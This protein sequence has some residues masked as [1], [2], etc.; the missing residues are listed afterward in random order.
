MGAGCATQQAYVPSQATS[1]TWCA[2]REVKADDELQASVVV[3]GET[4]CPDAARNVF[5][6]MLRKADQS[7]MQERVRIVAEV[8]VNALH[9]GDIE[10]ARLAF[11]DALGVMGGTISNPEMLQR[12]MSLSGAEQEKIFKGEPHER[13]LCYLYRG[14]LYMAAGEFDNARAC[15]KSAE[16]EDVRTTGNQ[17]TPGY[18]LSARYFKSVSHQM[19]HTE[20]ETPYSS[21][22]PEGLGTGSWHDGD[23]TIVIIATGYAPRKVV[24][25]SKGTYGLSYVPVRSEV[26]SVRMRPANP[27]PAVLVST[28]TLS[29]PGLG[30]ISLENPSEDVFVQAI[31]RGRRDMDKVLEAK[32]GQADT[33]MGVAGVSEVVGVTAAQF[34]VYGLP[35]TLLSALISTSAKNQA[36]KAEALADLRQITSLPGAL[37]MASLRSSQS[38]VTLEVVKNN[39]E[40]LCTKQFTLAAPKESRINVVFVRIHK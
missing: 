16:L 5:S 23:D 17:P 9:Y 20:D 18:W 26:R 19:D 27:L 31:S 12:V 14:L 25:K 15:F 34:G 2:T 36:A 33:A 7:P 30:E 1:A 35:V 40:V 10:H 4:A 29:K 22:I 24:N 13:A 39:G 38:P 32:K 11:D 3:L 28:D 8:G 6:D 37:Y 21:N